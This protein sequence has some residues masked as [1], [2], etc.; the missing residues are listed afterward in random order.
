MEIANPA[1]A[2]QD[3]RIHIEKINGPFLYKE[4]GSPAEYGAGMKL[5]IERGWLWMHESGTYVIFTQAGAELFARQKCDQ[6][7]ESG[8]SYIC[9]RERAAS[10][11]R[12]LTLDLIRHGSQRL[13]QQTR[14]N[15]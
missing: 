11:T 5:A 12:F 7:R 3:G 8:S 2:V 1:E 6:I 13:E 10:A 9:N 4:R 14:R 15:R